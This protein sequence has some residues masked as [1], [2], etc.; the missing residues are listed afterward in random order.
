MEQSGISFREAGVR[1][2]VGG[3]SGWGGGRVAKRLNGHGL[4]RGERGGEI[5]EKCLLWLG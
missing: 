3:L 4:G 5:W 2:K 1:Q